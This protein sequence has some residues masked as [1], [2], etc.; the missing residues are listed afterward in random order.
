M[1]NNNLTKKESNF[2]KKV[3]ILNIVCATISFVIAIVF[4][5][6]YL[7]LNFITMIFLGIVQILLYKN[8]EI[9]LISLS[10][11]ENKND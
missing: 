2:I 11:L 3:M 6:Y 1:G 5:Y 9:A 8:N 10:P 4:L 7:F